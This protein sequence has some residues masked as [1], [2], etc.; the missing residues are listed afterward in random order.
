MREGSHE[1]TADRL[2]DVL[3]PLVGGS[4]DL[5]VA[6]DDGPAMSIWASTVED[7]T[8]ALAESGV[9]GRVTV[10]AFSIDDSGA[11]ELRDSDGGGP[12]ERDGTQR[13][14]LLALTDAVDPA[15]RAG[16]AWAALRELG[17]AHPVAVVSPLSWPMAC[18][19]GLDL[20]RLRLRAVEPGA[21]NHLQEWERQ[22][23]VP[24]LY[25]DLGDAVPIPFVELAPTELGRWADLVGGNGWANLGAALVPTGADLVSVP[26][27][28]HPGGVSYTAAELVAAYR[29]TASTAVFDLAVHL[30]AAPLEVEL[31]V[32]ILERLHPDT[33]RAALSEFLGGPLVSIPPGEARGDVD[34]ADFSFVAEGVRGELLAH[35]RRI[36]TERVR[37][38]VRRY[39]DERRPGT[40]G[41]ESEL[42]GTRTSPL[43]SITA[44]P[45]VA[46]ADRA[47]RAAWSGVHL[48]DSPPGSRIRLKSVISSGADP[49]FS[50]EG[51][52]VTAVIEGEER[53]K[54]LASPVFG[55]VPPRNVDFTGRVDLL[56][57][58]G[59]RL[60]RGATAA[61][62]PEVL[63]GMA[64]A[65]KSYLAVEHAYRNR[66]NF[67]LIWWIP[68]AR[69]DRIVNA[70]VELGERLDLDLSGEADVAARQVLDALRSGN[71][72]KVPTA[73]LLVFDNADDPDAVQRYLP[74]GGTGRVLVTSRNSRWSSVARPLEVDVFRR[75]E[76][77]Q[78][79]C[80]RDPDLGEEDA[81]RLAEA[82]GD[83][84]LA[85]AQAAAWRAQT[86]TPAAEYLELLAERRLELL[87]L[88]ATLDYPEPVAAMWD[89][90]LNELERMNPSAF[91]LLQVCAFLAPE[92]INRSV[93]VNSRE[94]TDVPSELSR[95]LRDR[96]RLN[97]AI[98]DMYRFALVRVEHRTNSIELHRL[99]QAVLVGRMG[100]DERAAMRNAAHLMLGENDPGTP[101]ESESWPIYAELS[102]HL[103]ASDAHESD[104][105]SV[106]SLLRNY[107]Q[108]LYWCGERE[109]SARLSG[110]LYRTWLARSGEDDLDTL[111]MGRWSGFTLGVVGRHDEAAAMN[112]EMLQRHLR[113]LGEAHEQTVAAL[114][115]VVAD[116][117]A[118]GDFVGALELSRRGYEICAR[119]LGDDDTAT[120]EAAHNLGAG[121]RLVGDF[122]SAIRLD[123]ETWRRRVR[124]HGPEHELS[125]RS[126]VGLVLDIRELGHYEVACAEQEEIVRAYER[127]GEGRPLDPD[128][129]PAVRHLAVARRKVGDHEGAL[130][131]AEAAFEGLRRQ[132]GL[133]HA[134]T[135]AAALA[136]SI[137]LRR[138]GRHE[139]AARLGQETLARY[140]RALG[141]DHPHTL[142]A[143]VN[144]AV[145]ARLMGDPAGARDLD[146]V[147]L[148]GFRARLGED[149][150]STSATRIHLASDLHGS[151]D[152]QG[153]HDVD[154]EVLSRVTAVLGA[155]HPTTLACQ[156]NLAQDLRSLGRADEADAL[157]RRAVSV[158]RERLGDHHSAALGLGDP[159]VRVDCDVDPMPL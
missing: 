121:L 33:T 103:A 144:V 67:D 22:V 39:L 78:L 77:V 3:A 8:R 141:P 94:I 122:V 85:V 41:F 12:P 15:W 48:R 100:E 147:T 70:L 132:Y 117:R 123:V 62:L 10:C 53:R 149:H 86:G 51:V 159:D 71:H 110:D 136:C 32:R 90:S 66:A 80:R 124:M 18:R 28:R 38:V 125:L 108:F 102:A 40:G 156:V 105:A 84:P 35:G 56:A 37:K 68:A 89:L 120:L 61:V 50:R 76:S 9:F 59:R 75:S 109:R 2:R 98:R 54:T 145:L 7:F 143:A 4:H 47:I 20:H 133:D 112:A 127:R 87:D 131:A 137:G 115:N 106:R 88:T 64:G 92:P 65:G 74:T 14:L 43:S 129:L 111:W 158:L 72:P 118:E 79:L 119:H 25:D 151:G 96:L 17:A 152:V 49:E 155:D 21:P 34:R 46:E 146:R 52:A 81:D 154:A 148:H 82:L 1:W 27:Q 104:A 107:V 140:A 11:A 128:L 142:G 134:E 23:D 138:L 157:R 95:V 116:R 139:T 13:R 31:L 58:L 150:P 73:W 60:A 45:H 36:D 24:G 19:T 126:K 57:E 101:R 114:A 113:V 44:P 99:V 42:D 55:G 63:H 130:A 153:A 93:F 16:G 30:A 29:A 97:E 6:V 5:V 83:L 91:R 69:S 26:F 135:L